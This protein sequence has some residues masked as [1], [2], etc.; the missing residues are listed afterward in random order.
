MAEH[1]RLDLMHPGDGSRLLINQ[2]FR[3]GDDLLANQ[4]TEKADKGDDWRG[5]RPDVKQAIENAEEQAGC[6]GLQI[7]F[8][9]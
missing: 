7:D 4:D 3:E 9:G 2:R 5:R 1:V 6:Q 8:H